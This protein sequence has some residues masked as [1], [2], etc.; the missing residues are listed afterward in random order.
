MLYLFFL[1]KLKHVTYYGSLRTNDA[2]V[3][4]LVTG[5]FVATLK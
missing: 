5:R 2:S 1:R 3:I 4:R